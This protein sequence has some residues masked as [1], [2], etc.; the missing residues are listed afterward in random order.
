MWGVNVK[1]CMML[2]SGRWQLEVWRGCLPAV[3][4]YLPALPDTIALETVCGHC[5][6]VFVGKDSFCVLFCC[7]SLVTGTVLHQ[8]C[9]ADNS[10]SGV[11][12]TAFYE[13]QSCDRDSLYEYSFVQ[14]SES[15]DGDSFVRVSAMWRHGPIGPCVKWT[16]L[17]EY[18]SYD[19]DNFV[20]Y[21]SRVIGAA[22]YQSR[23]QL[24]L[25]V[26]V[27][28]QRYNY[29]QPETRTAIGD[30]YTP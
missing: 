2:I 19:G 5:C 27:V 4:E 12:G 15:C 17:Y 25:C 9:D 24:Q 20:G 23:W 29:L 28:L 18:Q 8:S 14:V 10:I 13:Y 3:Q 16:V 26:K 1:W 7:I 22:L 6:F 11:T 21:E 30:F